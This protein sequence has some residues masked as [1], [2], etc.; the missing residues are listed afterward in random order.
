MLTT[1]EKPLQAVLSPQTCVTAL[2]KS[3]ILGRKALQT[4]LAI[5]LAV[6]AGAGSTTREVRGA[7][8]DLY[9]KAGYEAANPKSRHYKT[10]NRRV[11]AAASLFENIGGPAIL[12]WIGNSTEDEVIDS[13]MR[14]LE[15]YQF[16]SMDDVLEFTGRP[17]NRNHAGGRPKKEL[18][19][20][21]EMPTV[22]LN[23]GKLHVE[24][25]RNASAADLV[26]MAGRILRVARIKE[27][28]ELSTPLGRIS[29]IENPVS[30]RNL[31]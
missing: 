13:V 12:H 31:H 10:V 2:N 24:L 9:C 29:S 27:Q 16:E 11:S 14:G 1:H 18:E 7:L 19:E 26:K 8:T 28:Q 4:E 22:K 5:C 30:L 20:V 6:F 17:S 23:V 15:A 25:P 21:P 3:M